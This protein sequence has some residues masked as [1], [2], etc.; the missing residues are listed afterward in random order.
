MFLLFF[1]FFSIRGAKGSPFLICFD[2]SDGECA[3]PPNMIGH[4]ISASVTQKL[5]IPLAPAMY[6]FAKIC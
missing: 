6:G 1:S 4:F 2:V 3:T 5:T